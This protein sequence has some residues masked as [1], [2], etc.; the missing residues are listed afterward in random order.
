MYT[1]SKLWWDSRAGSAS[2]AVIARCVSSSRIGF[3][4]TLA[5]HLALVRHQRGIAGVDHH[6][7]EADGTPLAAAP[8]RGCR[9]RS[10]P[11]PVS[12]PTFR[13]A[14]HW[15]RPGSARPHARRPGPWVVAEH[16][17]T[18]V[19]PLAGRA[20]LSLASLCRSL[21]CSI[22]PTFTAHRML[23][24][25]RP[26]AVDRSS[27][28]DCTVRHS[29]SPA[30]MISTSRSRSF[31]LRYSRSVCQQMNESTVA[32]LHR[33]EQRLETGPAL[34]VVG[35]DVV[36]V[37]VVNYVPAQ[38]ICE[39]KAGVV[40]ALHAERFA[41]VVLLRCGCRWRWWWSFLDDIR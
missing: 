6:H 10:T 9:R 40:L 13:P 1:R 34:A 28:P 25:C 11:G 22:S 4:L 2:I 16:R 24:I 15:R 38:A 12:A 27:W 36:V 14:D 29:I 18:S 41:G 8:R 17:G 33:V 37:E 20:G 19:A 23:A 7:A 5:D 3:P 21:L 26:D 39:L 31:Q 32:V 30:R 35:A